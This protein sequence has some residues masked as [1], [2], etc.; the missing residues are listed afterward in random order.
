MTQP[1]DLA[2]A[3]AHLSVPLP[4][5]RLVGE[6]GR[7]PLLWITDAPA[8]AGL[9]AQLHRAHQQSGLW[10]LLLTPLDRTGPDY[11][12]WLSGELYPSDGGAAELYDPAALLRGWWQS[13]VSGEE[14]D[15]DGRDDD[16]DDDK[17]DDDAGDHDNGDDAE[18]A[19]ALAP[20][21]LT[22]PGT[23]LAVDVPDGAAGAEARGLADALQS[24]KDV[25]L[26]LV[27]AD[28]GAEAL[29][30]CGWSGPT[31]HEDDIAKVAAV[32]AD[33]ER[34]FGARVVDVGFDTLELSVPV[35]PATLAEALPVAAEH[36]SLC[37]DLVFQGTGSLTE[38][39]RELVGAHQ[40]SF[41]WD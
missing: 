6:D 33:W 40:W 28:S 36:I 25:R 39:A 29:A 35:P 21:G 3:L 19:E 2:A 23:A 20:Y 31:N 41:W 22:W 5:G 13:G 1:L 9:W 17:G 4:P 10:P 7:E 14:G 16:G 37:P 18:I 8:P 15:H 34:R 27:R 30:V 24:V 12:P 26:G 11:R 38:Y 32:L